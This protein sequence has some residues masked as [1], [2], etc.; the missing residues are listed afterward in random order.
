MTACVIAVAQVFR[1]NGDPVRL[2]EAAHLVQR[3][4]KDVDVEVRDLHPA[5]DRP[6]RDFD[7]G[8]VICSSTAA[9]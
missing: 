3:F 6:E 9:R 2:P 4:L 7:R 1:G 8:F 5:P